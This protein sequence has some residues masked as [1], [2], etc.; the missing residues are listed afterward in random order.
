MTV[1][2]SSHGLAESH[3]RA[4]GQAHNHHSQHMHQLA[5]DRYGRD[6][7]CSVKLSGHKQ[8]CHPVKG[9]QKTRQQ[10]WQ[11]KSNQYAEY[12][13]FCKIFL[14]FCIPPVNP[15]IMRNS[16]QLHIACY[17]SEDFSRISSKFNN[18]LIIVTNFIRRIDNLKY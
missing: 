5:S 11:R 1:L 13:S 18:L 2:F 12:T 9:L 7:I 14:H 10:V 16:T 4:H 8:I 15:I 17:I 6:R 3:G